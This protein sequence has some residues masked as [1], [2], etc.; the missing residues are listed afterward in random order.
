MRSANLSPPN[1]DIFLIK[2]L[3]K[4]DLEFSDE[5]FS[6]PKYGF[7]KLVTKGHKASLERVSDQI[8]NLLRSPR[9]AAEYL[10]YTDQGHPSRGGRQS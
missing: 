9:G 4:R 6:L 10:I 7:L 3:F 1:A 8:E 5:D 2:G